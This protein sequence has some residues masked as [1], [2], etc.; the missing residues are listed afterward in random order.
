MTYTKNRKRNF[1]FTEARTGM[2]KW[3]GSIVILLA[4]WSGYAAEEA[5]MTTQALETAVH[6]SLQ[7]EIQ[8][9][10]Q[11]Q[12]W[13]H[14]QMH[15]VIFVPESA[16]HLARCQGPLIVSSRDNQTLPVG[17]LKRSVSC[18]DGF[19]DWRINTSAKVT[20]S[21]PV[22]VATTTLNRNSQINANSVKLETRTLTRAIH[23]VPELSQLIGKQVSRRMRSGQIIDASFVSN[24]PLVEKGNEVVIIAAKGKLNASTKGIALENGGAGEQIDVQNSQSK[25][26]IRAV[27]TGLNQ[28]HTQF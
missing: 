1:R 11:Q 7:E 17:N 4:T 19:N 27:V 16:K 25:Q 3:V 26:V 10:A 13:Q 15:L 23:F 2:R 18:Q 20:L 5:K 24:P 21:V 9:V 28:V 22:A 12:N 14:H 6:L 8:R